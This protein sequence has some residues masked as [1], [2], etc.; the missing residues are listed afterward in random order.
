[1]KN[2]ILC[3]C[4]CFAFCNN[5]SSQIQKTNAPNTIA[6]TTKIVD[7]TSIPYTT[8]I[9]KPIDATTGDSVA[10]IGKTAPSTPDGVP[11]FENK[12]DSIEELFGTWQ[13]TEI[14]E[15][16]PDEEDNP[17]IESF[18]SKNR[19]YLFISKDSIV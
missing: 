2:F 3:T 9:S 1:M 16:N 5:N 12:V 8:S 10:V 15:A 13:L 14:F 4:V 18:Y 6:I 11:L 7:T 19:A 17:P